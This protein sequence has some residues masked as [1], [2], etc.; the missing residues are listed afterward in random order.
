MADLGGEEA[1]FVAKA[2]GA[3]AAGTVWGLFI[4]ALLIIPAAIG[5]IF[6]PATK[7]ATKTISEKMEN[8]GKNV[9]PVKMTK[10]SREHQRR[11][12]ALEAER[13]EAELRERLEAL[14]KRSK[15]KRSSKTETATV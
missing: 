15:A 10:A 1:G 14:K 11:L 13:E 8:L 5:A 6:V 12:A 9:E 7:K 2:T 3:A 4:S